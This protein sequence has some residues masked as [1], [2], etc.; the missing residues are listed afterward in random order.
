MDDNTEIK[1]LNLELSNDITKRIELAEYY[2]KI[3]LDIFKVP[4]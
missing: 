3:A 2:K 4:Q 1:P